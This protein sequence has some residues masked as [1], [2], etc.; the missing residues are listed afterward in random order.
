MRLIIVLLAVFASVVVAAR[1]PQFE[2]LTRSIVKGGAAPSTC[3]L[4]C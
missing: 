1:L 2:A 3:C 4:P